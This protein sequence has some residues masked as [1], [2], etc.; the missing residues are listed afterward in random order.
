MSANMLGRYAAGVVQRRRL[1]LVLATVVML[2]P[3]E[4]CPASE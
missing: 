3:R 2:A 1:V 4:A